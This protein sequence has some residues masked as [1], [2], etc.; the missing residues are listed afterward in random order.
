MKISSFLNRFNL[1]ILKKTDISEKKIDE[2]QFYLLSKL[3]LFAKF[4][5]YRFNLKCM[6]NFSCLELKN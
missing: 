6:S 4:S 5:R 3:D 1:W 2:G